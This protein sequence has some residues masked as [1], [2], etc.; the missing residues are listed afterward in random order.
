HQ[1][2]VLGRVPERNSGAGSLAASALLLDAPSAG[3]I[4]HPLDVRAG[5]AIVMRP[6]AHDSLEI[7]ELTARVT[8]IQLRRNAI[9]DRAGMVAVAQG[10]HRRWQTRARMQFAEQSLNS[11][12][13]FLVSSF[14][15]MVVANASLRIDQVFGRPEPIR[16]G[17]PVCVF[18]VERDW[19]FEAESRRRF[20]HVRAF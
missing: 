4:A 5:I 3:E 6:I 18:V 17:A 11:Y 14:A 20:R 10:F 19:I 12:F 7:S 13:G 9:A 16:V 15:E 2:N 1:V 8:E